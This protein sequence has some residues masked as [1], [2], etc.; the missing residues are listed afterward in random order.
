M[1][2]PDLPPRTSYPAPPW[3]ATGRLWMAAASAAAPLPLPPDLTSIGSPRR[4]VIALARFTGALPYDEFGIGS[5][6][7]GH[8]RV[9]LWCHRIWVN[10]AAALWGG[11]ELWG[12]PKE[13]AQ[14]DWDGS[15]VSVTSGA[16]PLASLTLGAPG[17]R[18]PALPV[19]VTGFG[20]ADER[21]MFLPGRV[22]ARFALTRIR[23]TDWS[24][25]LPGLA[26]SRPSL[27]A[28]VADPARFRFPAGRDL[29]P[30]PSHPAGARPALQER[31]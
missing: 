26:G 13:L 4:L 8:G 16:R 20:L 29:G 22:L 12:I 15:A 23:V 21:R 24:P 14:F 19:P 7:R 9:G 30:D 17:R 18:L 28:A 27:R 31:R 3:L 5:L 25:L 6:V 2:E 10:D 11:R 1:A